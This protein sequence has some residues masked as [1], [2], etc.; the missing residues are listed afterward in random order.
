MKVLNST[1]RDYLRGLGEQV[2]AIAHRPGMAELRRLWMQHNHLERV[3]PLV[4]CFP[5]GAWRELMPEDSMTFGDP[6]WN[7]VE[8]LLR[9]ILYHFKHIPDDRAI[10]PV[11]RVP[12]KIEHGGWGVVANRIGGQ[13]PTHAWKWDPPLKNPD[14]LEKLHYAKLVYDE[15]D[16]RQKVEA[17]WEVLDGILEVQPSG[18]NWFSPISVIGM[19]AEMRGLDQL[20]LDFCDRPEWVHEAV[21]FLAE[22]TRRM[23]ED[24]E[25]RGLWALNNRDQYVGSGGL[26]YTD[27]LPAADFDGVHVRMQDRWGFAEAQEISEVSPGM[28]EEFCLAYQLPLLERFGLNCYN[29][30]E[31]ITHKFKAIKKVPRLRR[32]SVSPFTDREVAAEELGGDYVYSWKPNPAMVSVDFDPDYVRAEV[33]KTLEIARGCVVEMIL[34]DTHT[35]QNEP[36]RFTKWAEI[37]REEIERFESGEF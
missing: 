5:E 13:D 21:R 27:E 7:E 10:E 4:L 3:R 20:M 6:F 22:G 36:G 30:C 1:E 34:K 19:L 24:M 12:I 28:F 15:A 23:I 14:D 29:C 9:H 26:G 11:F 35:I 18:A 32:V 8:W 17:V 25:A 37:C 33:R 2:A 16:A 31:D